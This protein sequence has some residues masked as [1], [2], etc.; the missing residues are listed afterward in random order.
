MLT[1][2]VILVYYVSKLSVESIV[3][4]YSVE[5]L[6]FHQSS[7]VLCYSTDVWR[8]FCFSVLRFN[9]QLLV[10]IMAWK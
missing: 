8:K 2:F 9:N 1:M 7:S 10:E 5:L 6:V 4:K 3:L